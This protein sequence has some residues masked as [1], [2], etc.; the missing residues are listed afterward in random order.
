[1]LAGAIGALACFGTTILVVSEP[2]TFGQAAAN[3]VILVT[4]GVE[5]VDPEAPAHDAR[6]ASG[7]PAAAG[8]RD[9]SH[10]PG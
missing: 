4:D 1:V 3:V 8:D 10:A 9:A 5:T 6:R 2:N 7:L